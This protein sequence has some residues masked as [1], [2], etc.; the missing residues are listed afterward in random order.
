L[1]QSSFCDA[2]Q[3]AASPLQLG[4]LPAQTRSWLALASFAVV[5]AATVVPWELVLLPLQLTENSN[6]RHAMLRTHEARFSFRG[7]ATHSV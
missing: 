2:P 1:Q 5:F 4:A 7:I 3:V 6:A